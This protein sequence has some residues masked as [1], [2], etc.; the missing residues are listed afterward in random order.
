MKTASLSSPDL[1][2]LSKINLPYLERLRKRTILRI[3]VA[4]LPFSLFAVPISGYLCYNLARVVTEA[5]RTA[6]NGFE[7]IVAGL[8]A[9]L[10]LFVI[11]GSL[12]Y[13]RKRKAYA[14]YFYDGA[15]FLAYKEALTREIMPRL[16]EQVSYDAESGIEESDFVQ[17]G[18]PLFSS[19]EVYYSSGAL[20]GE[21][22]RTNFRFA[23]VVAQKTTEDN[24]TAKQTDL[25][26]GTFFIAD[27]HKKTS[28]NTIVYPDEYKY[29]SPFLVGKL[30]SEKSFRQEDYQ[31]IKL[32]DPKFEELFQVYGTD[33][34]ES[35]YILS[36]ALMSRMVEFRKKTNR[37][38]QFSFKDSK[39]YFAM[40]YVVESDRFC[41]PLFRLE[42]DTKQMENY[43]ADIQL[44][45][46]IIKELNINSTI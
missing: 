10:I 30:S 32:E 44:M 11:I 40:Y 2:P 25:F 22:G 6:D 26:Y 35:R 17:S 12:F 45:L 29:S 33:Q 42:Q 34:V 43:V 9:F 28:H 24:K 14:K 41:P 13:Q 3:S 8:G 31:R 18:F 4:L 5:Y 1:K 23:E 37:T 15:Y 16:G 7:V 20:Y 27:T 39:V 38:I 36:P 46:D 21:I 19:P